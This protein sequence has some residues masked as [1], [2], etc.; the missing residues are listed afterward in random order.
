[1][2]NIIIA[3]SLLT[4]SGC[5]GLQALGEAQER[6]DR[7]RELALTP[8]VLSDEHRRLILD[9]RIIIGMSINEV[10]ASLGLPYRQDQSSSGSVY[11]YIDSL[12]NRY[13]RTRMTRVYFNNDHIVTFWAKD[14]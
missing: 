1:M 6:A 7:A 14:G 8:G 13:S 4:I 11:F 5:A 2:K 3:L 10:I 9:H 12:G